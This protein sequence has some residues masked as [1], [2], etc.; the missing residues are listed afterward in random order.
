MMNGTLK[1]SQSELQKPESKNINQDGGLIKVETW[2]LLAWMGIAYN[3]IIFLLIITF[4]L[5]WLTNQ[6]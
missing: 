5:Y 4:T 6:E 1:K 3:Y 2:K